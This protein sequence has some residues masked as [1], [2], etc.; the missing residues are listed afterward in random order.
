M[1]K[2]LFMTAFEIFSKKKCQSMMENEQNGILERKIS[3]RKKIGL[4]HL[5]D[6]KCLET[7]L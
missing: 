1:I 6:T 3:E 2:T 4:P 5:Q 7:E